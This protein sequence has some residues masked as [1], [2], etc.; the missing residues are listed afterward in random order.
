MI[1]RCD[2]AEREKGEFLKGLRT[3]DFT[4][5]DVK[6]ARNVVRDD[7]I[8]RNRKLAADQHQRLFDEGFV[9]DTDSQKQ[10]KSII[11]TTAAVGQLAFA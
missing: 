1:N 5:A 4:D 11:D 10:I 9:K 7:V 2:K 6:A 3:S 8:V